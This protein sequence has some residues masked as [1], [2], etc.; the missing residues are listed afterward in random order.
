MISADIINDVRRR[1]ATAAVSIAGAS[2]TD[3]QLDILAACLA[4]KSSSEIRRIFDTVLPSERDRTGILLPYMVAG[5]LADYASRAHDI[6][7][8]VLGLLYSDAGTVNKTVIASRSAVVSG[9]SLPSQRVGSPDH[10]EVTTMAVGPKG[11]K[12]GGAGAGPNAVWASVG[13][14]P[15][16]LGVGFAGH[17]ELKGNI[18]SGT[19]IVPG[20]RS[21]SP[22]RA[23]PDPLEAASGEL[24]EGGI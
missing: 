1:A 4:G 18:P 14:S 5:H 20:S 12:A 16:S 13:L 8:L 3:A 22:S 2:L 7:V 19:G 23:N 9:P 11:L 17:E 6:V 10:K 24:E 15:S 21:A